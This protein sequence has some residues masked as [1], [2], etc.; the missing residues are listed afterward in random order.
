MIESMDLEENKKFN[1]PYL[2]WKPPRGLKS[3][4]L[5][6]FIHIPSLLKVSEK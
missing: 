4:G 3:L 2:A 6:A 1:H 5:L